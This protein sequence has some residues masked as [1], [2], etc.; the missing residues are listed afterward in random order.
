[1]NWFAIGGMLLHV[2]KNAPQL[3]D[4]VETLFDAARQQERAPLEVWQAV[5]DKIA[6]TRRSP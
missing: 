3:V 2:L 5:S 6:E 4:A 1:M